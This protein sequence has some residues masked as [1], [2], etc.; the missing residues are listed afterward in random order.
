MMNKVP[1]LSICIPTNG[2][3]DW[4]LLVLD[5]IYQQ[6]VDLALFEVVIT[7]NG[8]KSFLEE[9]IK[10]Y[11]YDNLIYIKTE[12]EGFQ[13][14]ISALKLANGELRKMLNHRS[15][16]LPGVIEEWIFIAKTYKEESPVIYF[17][18]G[19]LGG[20]EFIECHNFNMFVYSLSY[21][22]SWS[23]GLSIWKRDIENL[24]ITL[25]DKMFPNTTLLFSNK[26]KDKYIIWNKKFQQMQDDSGKGG[27]NLF[28]T[29]AID[30]LDII[31]DLRKTK[32]ITDE[33]FLK[34]KS[35]LKFFLSEWYFYLIVMKST[36]YDF[37]LTNIKKSILIYY[38]CY[39]Y[40]W[41]CF[42]A[43]LFHPII[44]VYTKFISLFR[45][46]IVL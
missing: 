23:A 15:I 6:G 42:M 39:T 12:D 44:Y 13:N 1:L 32:N 37:Y 46:K 11:K 2:A 14:L 29:F 36:K 17:S 41:I 27:Y 45:N 31:N 22:S 9:I 20:K 40:Y 24:D 7:D 34:I 21:Y 43:Y 3:V 38:T 16:L 10:S 8:K 19:V 33:T 18:D 30:Y 26:N 5:S 28:S 4:V 35:D 25:Y